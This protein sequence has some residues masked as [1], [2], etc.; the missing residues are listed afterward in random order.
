MNSHS[1]H[2]VLSMTCSLPA[3]C[4]SFQCVHNVLQTEALQ[5]CQRIRMEVHNTFSNDLLERPS[6]L[7][8]TI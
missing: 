8:D 2:C 5:T 4:N 3:F 6:Q 1:K 7:K